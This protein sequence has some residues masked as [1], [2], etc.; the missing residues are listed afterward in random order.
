MNE[1]LKNSI[2]S[3]SVALLLCLIA[4]VSA[5]CATAKSGAAP[6]EAIDEVVDDQAG[7]PFEAAS[8]W[9]ADLVGR[10]SSGDDSSDGSVDDSS[11]AKTLPARIES[12]A[13]QWKSAEVARIWAVGV[14]YRALIVQ[15]DYVAPRSAQKSTAG[16][17]PAVLLHLGEDENGAWEVIGLAPSTSTY[18]WSR[19]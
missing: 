10:A 19:L 9:A 8:R 14:E 12:I 13:G 2:R 7:D 5:G 17:I 4:S 16:Q 15:Y 3:G 18:L 11:G 6:G 1:G